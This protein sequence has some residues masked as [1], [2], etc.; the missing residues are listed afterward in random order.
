M[1]KSLS[2]IPVFH[3]VSLVSVC[4]RRHWPPPTTLAPTTLLAHCEL[5]WYVNW[6]S[7]W[8]QL[9]GIFL[10]LPVLMSIKRMRSPHKLRILKLPLKMPIYA[11]K[12][13]IWAVCGNM[14]KMRQS[15]IRIELA[16]PEAAV[17]GHRMLTVSVWC[18]YGGR[19]GRAA[20]S[21][22]V[23]ACWWR[24]ELVGLRVRKST[25]TVDCRASLRRRSRR[26]RSCT[27]QNARATSTTVDSTTPTITF[28]T[29]PR[30]DT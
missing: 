29:P 23:S 11:K 24:V 21:A 26:R 14:R 7:F 4:C 20:V 10:L 22:S 3:G 17:C 8:R 6:A 15:H 1:R 30:A 19:S 25:A 2:Y 18:V 13:A 9:G 12:Y 16:C 5:G 28:N 27:T